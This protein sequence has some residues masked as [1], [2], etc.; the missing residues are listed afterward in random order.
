VPV[1]TLVSRGYADQRRKTIDPE[2]A[3][4]SK[5][6]PPGKIE[7][8]DTTHYTV[9]DAEGNVVTTTYTLND[10]YGSGVTVRGGGFLLNNEMDDFAARPGVPND[11]ELIQGEANAIAPKKRPLSSMTPAI[12]LKDGQLYF[13]IGS[14]G[15]P[16]IINTVLQV[17]SNIID[18]DMNLQQAIEAPRFHHQWLP[19][20]I[21]WELFDLQGDT[22]STLEKMGH[23]FRD[24]PGFSDSDAIGDAHGVMIDAKTGLRLGGADPRRGGAAAG[25]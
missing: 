10:S 13:A 11:Y 20:Q 14:P 1:T 3:T 21:Y 6:T 25:W 4:P 8:I 22:R 17:I 2:H 24:R 23:T 15:G 12:V 18:F 5:G 9:V 16:T 19:D 7:S